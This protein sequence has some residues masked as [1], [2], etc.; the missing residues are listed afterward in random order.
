M[1][2]CSDDEFHIHLPQRVN[3][4]VQG[5]HDTD[6]PPDKGG[7][8]EEHTGV[9]ANPSQ[10][11]PSRTKKIYAPKSQALQARVK[12]LWWRYCEVYG[13][14][15]I[16]TLRSHQ[17][18]DLYGF[19]HWMLRER[20]GRIKKARTV[21]TYWNTLTLIHQLETRCFDIEPAVQVEMCGARQN[22][23]AEFNLSVEKEAKPIMR[24]EDEFE[25]LK[26]LWESPEMILQHERLRVQ[27]ALMIQLAG[28]TGSR[29][30]AL[31]RLQ[32][33]DLKIAPLPNSDGDEQ[34]R[35]VMDFTFQHT[36][37]YLG[38]K[39]PNTFPVPDIPREPC[40][41]LC[42]QTMLLSLLFADNAIAV[43][44]LKPKDLYALRIPPGKRE[45]VIPIKESKAELPLFRKVEHT[46]HGV[47]ISREAGT[48]NWL[49]E[50]LHLLGQ[51]AGFE[52]PVKPYC[53]RRAHGE[54]LDSSGHISASQRNL[55]MQH[56][57]SAVFEHNY[58]SHYITQDTQAAYRGL[59]PQTA[60]IRAASGMSRS[61]DPHRPRVLNSRQLA[62][63]DRHPEV[64]LARSV[65][66]RTA[67]SIRTRHTT[68]TRC[69]CLEARKEYQQAQCAYLR[70]K[71]DAR[72]SMMKH[73]RAKYRENQPVVDILQQLR[74]SDTHSKP[75]NENEM[76]NALSD[77]RRRALEALLA[78]AHN[79][80]TQQHVRRSGAI[81]A[82]RALCDYQ[83]PQI[84]RACHRKAAC[85]DVTEPGSHGMKKT[86][87]EKIGYDLFPTRCQPTQCIFCIGDESLPIDL[88]MKK[89]R[90]RD[91]LKRHFL[92]KH[93]QHLSAGQAIKCPHPHC[94]DQ[95]LEHANHGPLGDKFILRSLGGLLQVAYHRTISEQ[96]ALSSWDAMHRDC[97][98]IAHLFDFWRRFTLGSLCHQLANKLCEGNPEARWI[99]LLP[100]YET[101]TA[102][103]AIEKDSRSLLCVHDPEISDFVLQ[104]LLL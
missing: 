66:D 82:V 63:L 85:K 27:L 24:A 73:I 64:V 46:T 104:Y 48:E 30:G 9:G 71:R 22:L 76:K 79:K 56:S 96:F 75:T 68:I 20:E 43:P 99:M 14:H 5:E 8:F 10:Y 38:A 98:A 26:T 91:C 1:A 35:L 45:L 87:D 42:P 37:R 15:P 102:R 55:I 67:Q 7:P 101:W 93:L 77:K 50:R 60:V 70:S 84:R 16:D 89:F 65:R 44:D 12:W 72:K 95:W 57:S 34:P 100:M 31:R 103:D 86:Q 18:K 23:V 2:D 3:A 54:A 80:S 33:K 69:K 74:G 58:L 41:L 4:F 83:Q 11:D 81:D 88:R 40:L 49:R 90:N 61:I 17:V 6:N 13:K 28:I 52:V 51:I 92:R 32:Y 47:R 36:K 62:E 25:L 97:Q 59:E 19:F 29:P 39:D 78:F 94:L 53:F 21:Q